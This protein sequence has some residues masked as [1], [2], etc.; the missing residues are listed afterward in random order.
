LFGPLN[1]R[2]FAYGD[3]LSNGLR[4]A[5]HILGRHLQIGEQFDL[6]AP[7]IE[8]DLLTYQSQHAAHPWGELR[9]D[10]VQFDIG[11]E[12]AVMAVR[13]QVVR[14][15][16]FRRA[17]GREDRLGAQL[18]IMRLV[19]ASARHVPLV[20]SGGWEL[21]QMAEGGC[22][23]PMQGRAQGY[24]QGFQFPT[25]RL[26]VGAKDHAQQLVY[27]ARDFLLDGFG[28]FF[29]WPVCGSSSAGRK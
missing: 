7:V 2:L 14:P 10:D 15:P 29:S 6:L 8:R 18:P 21:Q 12:L 27:F 23:S 13:A 25:P 5:L 9:V 24:F 22:P 28:R 19:A 11:R 17:Y 4:G 16:Y 20:G 3:I 1:L 26:T